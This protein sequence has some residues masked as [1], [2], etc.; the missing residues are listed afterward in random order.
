MKLS[1]SKDMKTWTEVT[2]T[3][4]DIFKVTVNGEAK[5]MLW[6]PGAA[7]VVY[8]KI[9]KFPEGHGAWWNENYQRNEL[10]KGL[11]GAK[12]DDDIVI[13]DL[14]EIPNPA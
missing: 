7:N 4:N 2:E 3:T 8:L 11:V 13:S 6:E 10:M 9:E 14:D 12:D 1:Y 5:D